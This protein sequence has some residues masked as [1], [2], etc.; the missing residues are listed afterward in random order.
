MNHGEN[1]GVNHGENHDVNRALNE[2]ENHGVNQGDNHG[3]PG[4][5][6][7]H[8]VPLPRGGGDDDGDISAASDVVDAARPAGRRQIFTSQVPPLIR[9]GQHLD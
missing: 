7:S 3:V 2:D 1:H 9:M 6:N 8:I 4:L 5:K